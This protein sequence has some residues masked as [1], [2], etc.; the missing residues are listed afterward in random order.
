MLQHF[1]G[2]MVDVIAKVAERIATKGWVQLSNMTD[3]ILMVAD[4]IASK[5]L[6]Y[7]NLSSKMLNRTSSYMCGRRYLSMFLLRDGLLTLKYN[8][9]LMVLMRF[10]SSFPIILKFSIVTI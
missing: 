10:W 5:G 9:S 7:F 2:L 8:A 4:G 1:V 6:F 3:V